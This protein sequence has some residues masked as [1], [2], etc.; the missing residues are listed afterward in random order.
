MRGFIII[1]K[2]VILSLSLILPAKG[3]LL[4][5]SGVLVELTK[6]EKYRVS[7][8]TIV[9]LSGLISIVCNGYL[10]HTHTSKLD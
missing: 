5:L 7:S 4:G 8:N 10:M 6:L 3:N 1:F 9:L 2:I